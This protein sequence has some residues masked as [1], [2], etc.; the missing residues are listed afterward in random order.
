MGM[1]SDVVRYVKAVA[2]GKR[3]AGIRDKKR[4]IAAQ[5]AKDMATIDYGMFMEMPVGE[6]VKGGLYEGQLVDSKEYDEK[7]K[8]VNNGKQ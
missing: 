4:R 2:R 5:M 6:Y 1:V 8:A 3:I 7:L